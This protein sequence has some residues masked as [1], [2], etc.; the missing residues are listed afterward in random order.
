MFDILRP[1]V[2]ITNMF[3][4]VWF[5][6]LQYFRFKDT[7]RACSGEFLTKLPGNFGTVYLASQGDW[8]RLYIISHYLV[9]IVQKVLS[10]VITN[11]LEVQYDIKRNEI[12]NK[13]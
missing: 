10:I 12:L 1:Y 4:L 7:G 11:K 3:T 6:T 5:M 13:V 8:L 9:Y 2:I